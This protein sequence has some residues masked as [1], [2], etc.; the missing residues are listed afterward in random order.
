MTDTFLCA[1]IAKIEAN[2]EAAEDA[3][4]DYSGDGV[5]SY[6]FNTGQTDQRVE[7]A[8]LKDMMSYYDSLLAR[9]DTLRQRC[10][11]DNSTFNMVPGY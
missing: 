8:S 3:M 10:N 11:Q 5:I 7:K 1:R 6:T 4:L 2:I 9:R